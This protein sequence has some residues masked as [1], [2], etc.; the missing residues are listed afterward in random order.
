MIWYFAFY[1][2][3]ILQIIFRTYGRDLLIQY[4]TLFIEEVKKLLLR[5]YGCA[6]ILLTGVRYIEKRYEQLLL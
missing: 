3:S 2:N 6:C 5:G 1:R 4:F